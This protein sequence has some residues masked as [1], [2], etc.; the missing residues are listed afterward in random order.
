MG[1][2]KTILERVCSEQDPLS[3]LKGC[4]WGSG[5]FTVR[6][7]PRVLPLQQ[8]R[9]CHSVSVVM[10]ISH[11]SGAMFEEHCSNISGDV[12]DSVF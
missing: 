5:F 8:H 11:V 1:R 6:V 10:Y 9:W 12:L 2:V 3:H 4:K 7:A